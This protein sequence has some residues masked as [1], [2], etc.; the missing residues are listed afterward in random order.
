MTR[1]GEMYVCGLFVVERYRYGLR[2]LDKSQAKHQ[3]SFGVHW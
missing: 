1:V 3:I 2:D